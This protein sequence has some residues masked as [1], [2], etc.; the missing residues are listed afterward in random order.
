MSSQTMAVKIRKAINTDIEQIINL[1]SQISPYKPQKKNYN[2]IWSNL[3]KQKQHY[4]IVAHQ[5][6]LMLGYG[7]IFIETK[8]RGGKVGHIEDIVTHPKYQK[9]GI[10][11]KILQKLFNIAKKEK[12]FKMML[13]CQPKNLKFYKKCNYK[14]SGIAMQRFIK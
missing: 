5:K 6:N 9:K 13:Q 10:G 12:C 7:S 2:K 8:I 4:C 3:K 1:L 14:K 11:K